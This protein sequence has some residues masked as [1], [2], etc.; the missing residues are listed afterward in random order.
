MKKQR[1]RVR[2]ARIPS[3]GG[4]D[5]ARDA[6]FELVVGASCRAA[7]AEAAFDEPDIRVRVGQADA[8]GRGQAPNPLTRLE[9][10]VKEAREQIERTAATDPEQQGTIAMDLTPAF[11]FDASC[12][13]NGGTR[14]APTWVRRSRRAGVSEKWASKFRGVRAAAA[15]TRFAVVLTSEMIFAHVRPWHCGPVPSFSYT[16]SALRR[17]LTAWGS[18]LGRMV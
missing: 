17:F 3:A 15:Y 6:Q 7:G 5:T 12:S 18:P 13:R 8:R 16:A 1:A 2:L 10:R 11:G 14:E 9:Q 4:R